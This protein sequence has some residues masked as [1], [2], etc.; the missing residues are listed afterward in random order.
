MMLNKLALTAIICITFGLLTPLP[1]QDL[2]GVK[3]T[4]KYA[5]FLISKNEYEK[6]ADEYE[7]LLF[8]DSSNSEFYKRQLVYCYYNL[9]NLTSIYQLGLEHYEGKESKLIF[10]SL[11]KRG[12]YSKAFQLTDSMKYSFSNEER[13]FNQGIVYLFQHDFNSAHLL[14]ESKFKNKAII[15]HV[16]VLMP[17]S[18][19]L[20]NYQIKS[21][22]LAAGMSAVIPSSGR[23]YTKDYADAAINFIFI[24]VT[25]LQAYRGF[26][27]PEIGKWQGWLYGSLSTSFYLGNIFGSWKAAKRY[28][29]KYYDEKLYEASSYIFD[30]Y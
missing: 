17:I 6:A 10:K 20:N 24:S 16:N 8:L 21:P 25:A 11:L 1:A 12:Y 3:P 29:K 5:E 15:K 9:D 7:R 22:L 18:D 23:L 28:N 19:E 14:L 13:K 26:T 2:F 27:N 4:E 30:Y